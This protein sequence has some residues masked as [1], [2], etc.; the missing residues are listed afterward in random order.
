[1]LYL[2]NKTQSNTLELL[3][4]YGANGNNSEVLLISDAVYYCDSAMVQTMKEMGI[5]EIYLL[6]E[7]LEERNIKPSENCRVVDYD[8]IVPLIMEKHEKVITI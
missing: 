4:T 5:G 3:K 7:S 8:D 1:M 6:K 2:L